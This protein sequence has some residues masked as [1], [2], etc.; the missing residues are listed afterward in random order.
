MI[1][2]VYADIADLNALVRP[3]AQFKFAGSALAFCLV[4]N[5]GRASRW[6]PD[7]SDAATE[8]ARP[9]FLVIFAW[10]GVVFNLAGTR[11]GCCGCCY[12]CNKRDYQFDAHD[13]LWRPPFDQHL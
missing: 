10:N 5:V 1:A 11:L 8:P 7:D 6:C 13:V 9:L 3:T 12:S 2:T 4:G